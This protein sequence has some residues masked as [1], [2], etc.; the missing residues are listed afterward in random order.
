MKILASFFNAFNIIFSEEKNF[1]M[2]SLLK[3]GSLRLGSIR[4]R[5]NLVFNRV[6]VKANNE[7]RLTTTS[8][9]APQ[10]RS[11][12]ELDEA[13]LFSL[14]TRVLFYT[15]VSSAVIFSALSY[16]LGSD[17]ENAYKFEDSFPSIVKV[18]G[19]YLGLPVDEKTGKIDR[20]ILGARDVR[21]L[22]GERVDIQV[23]T[24]SGMTFVRDIH[25]HGG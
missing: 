24:K 8:A 15:T 16:W 18:A 22:V 1:K 9:P 25:R 20:S 14:R 11:S 19:S 2:I 21:D 5:N 4:H 3:K 17:R 23:K 13:P 7:R 6:K 10:P 12:F